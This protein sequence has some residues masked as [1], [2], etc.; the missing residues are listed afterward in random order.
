LEKFINDEKFI[1][2][3]KKK[4]VKSLFKIQVACFKPLY[5]GYDII[6]R[7]R[8]GSGKTLAFTLPII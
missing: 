6:A 7:D 1:K 5:E 4:G 2:L 8:T 3:L